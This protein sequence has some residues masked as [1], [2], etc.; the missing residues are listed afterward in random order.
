MAKTVMLSVLCFFFG[1]GY[2]LKT[3]A[4]EKR[5]RPGVR[6]LGR[7]KRLPCLLR[8]D[9]LMEGLSFA[10]LGTLKKPWQ[11]GRSVGFTHGSLAT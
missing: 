9:G 8:R 10:G 4:Q 3:C 1:G 2:I 7:L 11:K 6:S 5:L